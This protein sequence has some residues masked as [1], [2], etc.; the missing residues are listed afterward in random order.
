MRADLLPTDYDGCLIRVIQECSEVIK[1]ITKLQL[2][3]PNP[4]DHA[5]GI[6]YD[7]RRDI[8]DECNDLEHAMQ[9]IWDYYSNN[10]FISNTMPWG[11]PIAGAQQVR[12]SQLITRFARVI[13]RI[14]EVQQYDRPNAIHIRKAPTLINHMLAAF[15][16]ACYAIDGLRAYWKQ[17]LGLVIPMP[18]IPVSIISPE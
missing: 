14:A 2:Y 17:S 7:N 16:E 13:E 6:S 18:D 3:G 11:I 1:A 8:L 4:T 9:A 15:V 10:G 5:T 12:L